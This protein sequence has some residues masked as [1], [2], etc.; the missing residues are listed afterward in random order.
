[1]NY[2]R[3]DY[4]A[5][6]KDNLLIENSNIPYQRKMNNVYYGLYIDRQMLDNLNDDNEL[7]NDISNM[8]KCKTDVYWIYSDG[9]SFNNGYKNPD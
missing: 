6:K 3:A 4:N 1:M 8:Q 9:G 2:I 7:F 5:R